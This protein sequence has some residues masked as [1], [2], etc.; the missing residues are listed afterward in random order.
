MEA[1][2]VGGGGTRAAVETPGGGTKKSRDQKGSI[3]NV[4]KRK[5]WGG[6]VGRNRGKENPTGR[7]GQRQPERLSRRREKEET[8]QGRQKKLLSS[9]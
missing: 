4:R 7:E 2:R 5:T 1:K 8:K 3:E 9:S 6:G